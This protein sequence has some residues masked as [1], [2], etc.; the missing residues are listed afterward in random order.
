MIYRVRFVD[1]YDDE[2]DGAIFVEADD[3][4]AVAKYGATYGEVTEIKAY[5]TAP[6]QYM[7]EWVNPY[8]IDKI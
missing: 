4:V 1:K 2:V 5:K 8:L 6:R 3:I 7:G